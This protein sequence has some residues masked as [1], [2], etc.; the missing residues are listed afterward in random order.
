MPGRLPGDV[1]HPGPGE[2]DFA[3]APQLYIFPDDC[4]DCGMCVPACPVSAIHLDEELPEKWAQFAEVNAAWYRR[5]AVS[6]DLP[7]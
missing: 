6:G 1:I 7:S 2:A 5:G 4:I 3:V